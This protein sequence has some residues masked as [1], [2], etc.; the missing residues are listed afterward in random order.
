ME[1]FNNK[2]INKI[3]AVIVYTIPNPYD[4]FFLFPFLNKKEIFIQMSKLLFFLPYNESQLEPEAV[5][6]QKAPLTYC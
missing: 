2:K 5:K 3:N 1:L 6:L 4:L